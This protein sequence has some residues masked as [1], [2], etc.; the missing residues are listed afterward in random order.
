MAVIDELAGERTN[1]QDKR[2]AREVLLS[3]TEQGGE[4]PIMTALERIRSKKRKRR[5]PGKLRFTKLVR[6]LMDGGAN[7]CLTSNA[8]RL[9]RRSS[10][11]S[12]SRGAGGLELNVDCEGFLRAVLP[13][14]DENYLLFKSVAMRSGGDQTS[15]FE[16][17][18]RANR[19]RID[20]LT[21]YDRVGAL[22]TSHPSTADQVRRSFDLSGNPEF[23][24][25]DNGDAMQQDNPTVPSEEDGQSEEEHDQSEEEHSSLTA[26]P[27]NDDSHGDDETMHDERVAT[28]SGDQ[29]ADHAG[30]ISLRDEMQQGAPKRR[31]V[32]SDRERRELVKQS[33]T[34]AVD[35]RGTSPASGGSTRVAQGD[36]EKDGAFLKRYQKANL[37]ISLRTSN[38][39]KPGSESWQRYERYKPSKTITEMLKHASWADVVHDYKKG[40]LSLH[41][42]AEFRRISP[43]VQRILAEKQPPLNDH[44]S[45]TR[46]LFNIDSF[47]P[48]FGRR[49]YFREAAPLRQSPTTTAPNAL[50]E[51][52]EFTVDPYSFTFLIKS[53]S[54]STTE[55]TNSQ[56]SPPLMMNL[57]TAIIMLTM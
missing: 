48:F 32:V 37:P 56:P 29:Q 20:E 5:K 35:K 13:G 24:L 42:E 47:H 40:F 11:R 31:Q 51:E 7:T 50:T 12:A 43:L 6:F 22:G 34:E 4:K 52:E 53:S 15:P 10:P 33:E 44:P 3:V 46:I 19:S 28:T 16:I 17:M 55:A 21:E 54:T 18:S 36:S 25:D 23:M 57:Q 26:D 49:G 41:P 30:D 39:K 9:I 8:D 27:D 38:P 1:E 45:G 2:A 14:I